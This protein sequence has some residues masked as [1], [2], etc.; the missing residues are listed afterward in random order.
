MVPE[1][2]EHIKEE[3]VF[4]HDISN[5]LV[6]AQGMASFV[7]KI[8]KTQYDED[9]KEIQRMNKTLKAINAMIEMLTDRRDYLKGQG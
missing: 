7:Q 6:I 8:L 3:R 1:L 5:Q 4:L 9:A 2:R